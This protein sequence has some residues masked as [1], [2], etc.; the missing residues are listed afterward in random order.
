MDPLIEAL[1]DNE[2]WII[3]RNAAQTLGKL[4]DQRAMA[5]LIRALTDE[6]SEVR[7]QADVAIK[8]LEGNKEFR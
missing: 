4:K 8:M 6:N 2:N 7:K 5:P 1:R 3:R